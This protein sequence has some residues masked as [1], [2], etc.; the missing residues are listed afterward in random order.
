VCRIGREKHATS[1]DDRGFDGS[2]GWEYWKGDCDCFMITCLH[3]TGSAFAYAKLQ[4]KSYFQ[5]S[6]SLLDDAPYGGF[7]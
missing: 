2:R 1:V 3:A 5:P 6:S 7:S 4:I